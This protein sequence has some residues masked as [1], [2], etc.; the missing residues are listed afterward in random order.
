MRQWIACFSICFSI[1]G[2]LVI[3]VAMAQQDSPEALKQAYQEALEH[4]KRDQNL[5]A[6]EIFFNI[7]TANRELRDAALS[8]VTENLIEAGYMN[9]ASY[10]FIKTLQSNDRNAI[11]RVL[12]KLPD[13]IETVGGDLLR[14][15]VLRHT[16]ESDYDADTKNHFFYFLGKDHLLKGDVAESIR[17]LN[18]VH[19]GSGVLPAAMYLKGTA[20]AILGQTD[21]AIYAFSYCARNS[22]SYRSKLHAFRREPE[23][24]KARCTA[25]LAR[26]YYQKGD[27]DQAEQTW[28]DIPKESF[29]WTDILFEQAWNA[30][31]RKDYNR[32][33]GKLVT[34]RSPLLKFVFNPEVDVL[35]AQSYLMLCRYSD[36]EKVTIEF[37]KNYGDVGAII[38]RFL[39][40]HERDLGAFYK[41]AKAVFHR[42]IYTENKL[43]KVMNRFIRGPYFASQ[44]NQELTTAT[45]LAKIRNISKSS[46][47]FAGFVEK[48]L[49]WRLKTIRLLGGLFVKNSLL[50]VYQELLANLDKMSFIK[51]EMLKNAKTKLERAALKKSND[52]RYESVSI[53]RK[54]HQY[55]WSFNG[56]FWIDELGD[57]VFGLP[58]ECG[59]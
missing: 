54:G 12:I 26:V 6:A 36:V 18:Q 51:L 34:Y 50:D 41:L 45:E 44:Y 35:R 40:S 13:M 7:Y 8:K 19:S 27:H 58:S 14:P 53:S 47:G 22:S 10:F 30:Y 5:K 37:N 3:P 31:A 59:S 57:Y 15:Y 43:E 16:R 42:K 33:L 56:E 29:V 52:D 32:A 28:D 17:A 39:L 1:L 9:A 4:Q 20:L 46:E 23:D 38:K 21:S 2:A 49:T 25:S 24:L 55:Y 11:Q 48:V